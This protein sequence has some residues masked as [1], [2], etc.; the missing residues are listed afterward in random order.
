MGAYATRR[1]ARDRDDIQFL[2]GTYTEEARAAGP[3]LD[4]ENVH[5]FLSEL[6]AAGKRKWVEFFDLA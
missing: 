2:L 4:P 1:T 6:P 3:D 5:V